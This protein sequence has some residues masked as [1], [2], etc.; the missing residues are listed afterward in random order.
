MRSLSYSASVLLGGLLLIGCSP[1][2]SDPSKN[3]AGGT[4]A[5]A[6]GTNAPGASGG[7]HGTN[8][9]ARSYSVQKVT[10][11]DTQV[12][13]QRFFADDDL[14]VHYGPGRKF[15]SVTNLVIARG[16]RMY[17][18]EEH[19]GWIRFRMEPEGTNS[20][21]WLDKFASLPM[22]D[23]EDNVDF[24]ERDIAR[25]KQIGLLT[26][27]DP[28]QNDA[29]VNTNLWIEQDA[30]IR[31]GIGRTLAFYCGLKKGSSTR[32]VEIRDS[33]T[34]LRVAKYSESTGYTDFKTSRSQQQ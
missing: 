4:N 17:I 5:A 14:D 10:D 1:S 12:L 18:L 34:G 28:L 21:G 9:P 23:A 33:D 31:R 3:E 13:E 29:S 24:H 6:G 27:L 15:A 25:L 26:A 2:P 22:M 30:V 32:W 20:A 16:A 19:E 7:M 8:A 11:N